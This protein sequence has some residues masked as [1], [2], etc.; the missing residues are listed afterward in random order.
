MLKQTETKEIK[1]A[2]VTEFGHPFSV[3]RDR[4]T[5][6]HW[7]QIRW[8][9]GPTETLVR[10][11]TARYQDDAN[12]DI[13]TDLWV[14]GQYTLDSREYSF[15][16]YRW[17]VR[18]IELEF[19]IE[20]PI[21]VKESWRENGEMTGY[22]KEGYDA[23]VD[24]DNPDHSQGYASS[25]I[26]RL[27]HKTDF[28]DMDLTGF[29][30]MPGEA[31]D[32]ETVKAVEP[33]RKQK[34]VIITA[35]RKAEIVVVEPVIKKVQQNG[36]T[37]EIRKEKPRF[38][39]PA[40]DRFPEY[41]DVCVVE[42]VIIEDTESGKI[43]EH[44][45][46]HSYFE[47]GDLAFDWVVDCIDNYGRR[48]E[49]FTVVFGEATP[50]DSPRHEDPPEKKVD[51]REK[52][53]RYAKLRRGGRYNGLPKAASFWKAVLDATCGLGIRP[54]RDPRG[55]WTEL[56]E[57]RT[58]VP[59]LL[60]NYKDGVPP[61]EVAQN[62]KLEGGDKELYEKLRA[63]LGARLPVEVEPVPDFPPEEE[64]PEPLPIPEIK[65]INQ[66]IRIFERPEIKEPFSFDSSKDV[67]EKMKGYQ[68]ADREMFML[69]F[70][71][72]HNVVTGIET[73]AV[74][75]VNTSSVHPAQVFRS[76][77]L[78]N[79][80]AMIFVHNHPTGDPKPSESDKVITQELVAGAYFL[81]LRVLDHVILG[82]GR[83]FSFGD[84]GLMA[85]YETVMK[86][87]KFD[88]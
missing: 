39:G 10:A 45:H 26:N 44:G 35:T 5:A 16:A 72:A 67:Y 53:D 25:K 81:Q 28:R 13:M 86:S 3:R 80:C 2:L 76:A 73:H 18:Q 36:I 15:G 22:I 87:K 83:Y 37:T 41:C 20:I 14:G 50:M 70:L 68:K 19:S 11:F 17:A 88:N 31:K 64:S 62:M 71:D 49:D 27:L 57:F 51:A 23:I 84:E 82:D 1:R 79:A 4:G 8:T 61:D 34:P 29:E 46:S 21:T 56:E 60:R 24:P 40:E 38:K 43:T 52:T 32:G 9:D 48:P 12:D 30:W 74:G 42:A 78:N 6:S 75:A 58:A 69:L 55:G 66:D 54:Y 33:W 65:S 7:I 59:N 47:A 63:D 77:L 85:D